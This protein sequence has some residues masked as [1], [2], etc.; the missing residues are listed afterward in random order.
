MRMVLSDKVESNGFVLV[1]NL[2]VEGSK[3]KQFVGF[4]KKLP[5]QKGKILVIMPATNALVIRSA[6]N[7]KQVQVISRD[8]IDIIALMNHANV[9]TMPETIESLEKTYGAKL[10]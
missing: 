8:Q 9:V 1:D 4:L 2:L 5:L 10:K 3:T 6:R 7:I